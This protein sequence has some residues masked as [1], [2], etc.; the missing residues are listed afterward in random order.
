[1]THHEPTSVRVTIDDGNARSMEQIE[2]DVI[3]FAVDLYCGN[4]SEV[5]R[6]LGMGRSTLYRKMKF[7]GLQ[8]PGT[9]ANSFQSAENH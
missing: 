4:M 6:R 3:Q 2:C 8:L 7:Y 9:A 5:S 1:M